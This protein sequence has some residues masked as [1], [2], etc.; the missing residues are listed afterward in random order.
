[1]NKDMTKKKKGFLRGE[2]STVLLIFIAFMA[3]VVVLQLITG[4]GAYPSMI[5]PANI[6]N[7]FIQI[8]AVGI[9]AMGMTLVMISGGIDLSVGMLTSFVVLF[10]AKSFRDWDFP[11]AAAIIVAI[12]LAIAFETGM[13][14]IISRLGVEPFI[15]TLGGQI[16]FRGVALLIVNSQ[17]ISMSGA[18]DG[19]K[20][21]VIPELKDPTSGL[22]LNIPPYLFIFIAVTIVIWWLLKY[23]KYGRRIYAVGANPQAAYLA[24]IDVKNTLMST[25]SLNGLLVGI[26]AVCLLARVNTAIITTGQNLEIDVIAAV[27]VGGVAMSGGKGNA[28][29]VFLGA[30][31]MGAIA[32]GMNILRL[33]A[34][35]QYVA[36][37]LIIIAA[38]SAGAITNTIQARRQLKQQNLAGTQSGAGE[39]TN[40]Q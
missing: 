29:G 23:T 13:G 20:D 9:M 39:S 38:V 37:G 32:N 22:N 30:L 21:T 27:V 28:W 11:L 1:M 26:G 36:K 6:M 25:Y 3:A 15:I 35:W 16:A 14:F 18:L 4:G 2:N 7:I 24:G 5:S 8:S 17:E 31:L 40:K 33:Q 12:L 19:L 10:L 34:E